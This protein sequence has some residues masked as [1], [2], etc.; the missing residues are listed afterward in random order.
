MLRPRKILEAG[1][2]DL[3]RISEAHVSGTCAVP[4]RFT[5]HGCDLDFLQ[6]KSGASVGP[7]EF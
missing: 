3:V 2:V 1:T 5:L 4:W 6:G 7:Q